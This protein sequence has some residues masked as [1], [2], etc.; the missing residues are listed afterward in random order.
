[1]SDTQKSKLAEA[2]ERMKKLQDHDLTMFMAG[3][4]V[5]EAVAKAKTEQTES[6]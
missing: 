4:D 3:Y 2:T 1:M 5:G 6:K